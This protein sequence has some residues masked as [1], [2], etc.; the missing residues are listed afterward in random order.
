MGTAGIPGDRDLSGELDAGIRD[1][2]ERVTGRGSETTSGEERRDLRL[3]VGDRSGEDDEHRLPRAL[4]RIPADEDLEL[5]CCAVPDDV[6]AVRVGRSGV[7]RVDVGPPRLGVTEDG[8]LQAR[9]VQR[10][11]HTFSLSALVVVPSA[12]RR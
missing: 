11:A 12:A 5:P 10:G 3:A 9:L 8:F 1:R 7:E 6:D 4:E 2:D